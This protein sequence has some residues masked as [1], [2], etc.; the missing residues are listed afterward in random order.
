M[1]I[2]SSLRPLFVRLYKSIK[3]FYHTEFIIPMSINKLSAARGAQRNEN[4][5]V[6]VEAKREQTKQNKREVS[7][8]PR[9]LSAALGTLLHLYFK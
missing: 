3:H 7:A 9:A 2:T 6:D 5:N 8:A 1:V 4:V